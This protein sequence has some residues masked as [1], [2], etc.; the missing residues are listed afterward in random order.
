ARLAAPVVISDGQRVLVEHRA[1]DAR[2]GAH[3]GADLF[4]HETVKDVGR[5]RE[6]GDGG[7]GNDGSVAG[8][9][10]AK[11]GRS[12][13]EVEDPGATGQ[14]ADHKPNRVNAD[15]PGDLASRPGGGVELDSR[16]AVAFD[17]TF[18]GEEEIDPDRL[19]AGVAAPGAAHRRGDQEEPDAGH[20]KEAGNIDELLR[21]DLDE[22]EI[23]AAVRKVHQNGLIRRVGPAIPADPGCQIVD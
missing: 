21:P 1:L 13:G 6:N 14:Q 19:R 9:K 2:P 5:G 12:V 11:Q 8:D 7:V 4:A 18:N 10:V 23:E 15:A 22:E 3:I 20:D 16:V 17:E